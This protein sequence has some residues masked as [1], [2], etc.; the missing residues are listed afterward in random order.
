MKLIKDKLSKYINMKLFL[1]IFSLFISSIGANSTI[2]GSVYNHVVNETIKI[3]K[4]RRINKETFTKIPLLSTQSLHA[5]TD[6]NFNKQFQRSKLARGS[7]LSSKCNSRC[8]LKTPC[9]KRCQLARDRYQLKLAKNTYKKNNVKKYTTSEINQRSYSGQV[10]KGVCNSRCQAAK[11]RYQKE[12]TQ[13]MKTFHEPCQNGHIKNTGTLNGKPLSDQGNPSGDTPGDR[14]TIGGYGGVAKGRPLG[15]PGAGQI[16]WPNSAKY[17]WRT[18]C[19]SYENQDK[20]SSG[21]N[22]PPI[23]YLF[24]HRGV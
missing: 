16:N 1:Y 24:M 21:K 13:Y 7:A 3:L 8:S 20:T 15:A 2:F 19:K 5:T 14:T 23:D 17:N 9:N 10:S 11:T 4:I 6:H 12:R 18:A 22:K